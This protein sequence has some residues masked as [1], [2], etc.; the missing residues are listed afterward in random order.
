[1]KR[2]NRNLIP[3]WGALVITLAT[4]TACEDGGIVGTSFIPANPDLQIDTVQ[5]LS[6]T[7]EP[8]VSYAGAK[9]FAAMGRYQDNLFGTYE[10][11]AMITPGF[12]PVAD[13]LADDVTFGFILRPT[14][15]YGDTNSIS[16]FD[17]YEIQERWRSQEWRMD[18]T[19]VL[20][21]APIARF[22]IGDTD[23][24]FIPLPDSWKQHYLTYNQIA[25]ADRDSAYNQNEF[26]FAFVPVSGNKISYINITQSLFSGVIADSAQVLG[27]IRQQASN[28]RLIEESTVEIED[29]VKI[30][31]DF[32]R[33][34]KISFEINEQ[35]VGAKFV[36]RAELVLYEDKQLLQSTLGIGQ[37]R[38]SNQIIRLY[39]LASD[40]KEYYVTKDATISAAVND[41]GAYR[42]NITGLVNTALAEGGRDFTFY[43]VSDQDNGIIRPNYLLNENSGLR[44]P[45]IIVT[46]I[47]A[48]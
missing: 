21:S 14:Q 29:G 23:S 32:T 7:T 6:I 27:F 4:I 37:T 35:I 48:N 38:Y 22:E 1:M 47:Q 34:G 39:D 18:D 43:I 19:P 9:T 26:G 41:N 33:T 42:M 8:L 45:K 12:S 5:T 31:N 3:V 30:M 46:K 24:L 36:S 17:I 20:G 16:V 2:F 15:T 10:A 11:V 28:Y 44:A 25:E 40:E 13:S